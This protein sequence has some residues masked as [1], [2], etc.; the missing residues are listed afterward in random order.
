MPL[1]DYACGSCGQTT[2][3]LQRYEDPPLTICPHC[4]G[5]LRKLV[6]APSFQFKGSG[7]YVTDYARKSGGG[8]A[9]GGEAKA[10]K[11]G[12]ESS[13]SGDAGKPES[14]PA[15]GGRGSSSTG[16][17][18]SSGSGGSGGSGD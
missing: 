2:E 5:T 12:A 16:S 15:G 7:W 3:I 8:S 17:G 10:E 4:G 11:S 9:G 18:G 14:K 6:S 13:G 1:Y